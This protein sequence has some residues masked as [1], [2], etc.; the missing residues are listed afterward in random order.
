MFR[1]Y[2]GL[3]NIRY[4]T[5]ESGDISIEGVMAYPK[6]F[7]PEEGP[8]DL[9]MILS[10][11]SG[12]LRHPQVAY[13]LTA[14][15][16]AFRCDMAHANVNADPSPESLFQC[17]NSTLV[18]EIEEKYSIING[19]PL[20]VWKAKS[21]NQYEPVRASFKTWMDDNLTS[22][23]TQWGLKFG[24]GAKPAAK[25]T[26]LVVVNLTK[27]I[28]PNMPG[29]QWT[30]RDPRALCYLD[31]NDEN[32]RTLSWLGP[33]PAAK[34]GITLFSDSDKTVNEVDEE[35]L[36]VAIRLGLDEDEALDTVE[37]VGGIGAVFS[38]GAINSES[39][40]RLHS[41]KLWE[42]GVEGDNIYRYKIE[43]ANFPSSQ[44]DPVP[45]IRNTVDKG[46]LGWEARSEGNNPKQG[47]EMTLVFTGKNKTNAKQDFVYWKFLLVGGDKGARLAST[48]NSSPL[49]VTANAGKQAVKATIS[50]T[51]SRGVTQVAI[52]LNLEGASNT[53]RLRMSPGEVVEIRLSGLAGT[54]G[55]HD[56]SLTESLA[57]YKGNPSGIKLSQWAVDVVS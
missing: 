9:Y 8:L 3:Q 15:E 2:T 46:T 57:D 50:S 35:A 37:R 14:W 5:Q 21:W 53:N 38:R 33:A 26:P 47:G 39:R 40:A 23:L 27:M 18:P 30:G 55:T 6:F 48:S 28:K 11:D 41:W 22:G 29:F 51:S 12:T 25:R 54:K 13:D 16:L 43:A 34:M 19:E 52:L 31:Q 44:R 45:P 4:G 24:P 17:L 7:M 36:K 1:K 32:D 56:L 42:S 49:R 10:I 20:S